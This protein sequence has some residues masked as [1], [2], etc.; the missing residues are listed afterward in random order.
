MFTGQ[1]VHCEQAKHY[2]C[3][4]AVRASHAHDAVVGR[5]GNLR[6]IRAPRAR[7]HIAHLWRQSGTIAIT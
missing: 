7:V 1:P 2:E 3:A 5:G 4:Q 6:A